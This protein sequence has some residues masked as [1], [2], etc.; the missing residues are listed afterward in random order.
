M[1]I[2]NLDFSSPHRPAHSSPLSSSPIRASSPPPLSHRDPNTLPRF[3]TQSSPIRESSTKFKFA[4]NVKPN[5]LR[6]NRENAQES[7]RNLFLRNVR[8]RADDRQWERR[9]GDQETLKL[10][11]S[12]LDRQRRE[13]K[14]ADIDGI[15]FEDEID[16]ILELQRRQP[17]DQDPDE[18]MVDAMAQ[19][20]EAELNAMLSMLETHSS[21]PRAETTSPTLVDDDDY[22]DLFMDLLSQQGQT[23]HNTNQGF[24]SSGQMDMS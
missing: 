6:Q 8:K 15:V 21:Q 12:I 10:E 3:D 7:R 22:D 20:E 2:F 24:A 14:N 4:R 18:M 11:W 13:Q 16:D 5:P 9:G 23:S 19:E 17:E 1:P